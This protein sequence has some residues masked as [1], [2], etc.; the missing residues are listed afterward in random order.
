MV[1]LTPAQ[2]WQALQQVPDP[3]LPAVSICELGIVREVRTEA[4]A[5]TV[6]VTPTY[7]GC[8]ATELI[9]GDIRSALL[10]AGA[11]TVEVRTRLSPAWSSDWISAA[12]R[13]KLRAHGI[14]PPQAGAV[15]AQGSAQPLHFMPRALPCPRCGSTRTARLSEFGSTA[16]K[17]LYRCEECREPF[18]Y[19]KEI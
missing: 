7:S 14:V 6:V 11:G 9:A 17:A 16:C 19:F 3:E 2:A 5:V 10:R 15:P 13:D 1:S 4:D 18:E 8:P 12:A